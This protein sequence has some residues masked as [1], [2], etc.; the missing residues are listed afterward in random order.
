[1]TAL[2][3]GQS[4]SDHPRAASDYRFEHLNL[5]LLLRDMRFSRTA[6]GPVTG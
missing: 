5:G 3:S 4:S 2:T 6:L 1:M